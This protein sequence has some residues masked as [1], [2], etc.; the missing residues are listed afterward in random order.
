MVESTEPSERLTLATLILSR[1]RMEGDEAAKRGEQHS[2]C[3]YPEGVEERELER[4]GWLDGWSRAML[5]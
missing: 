5:R 2:L 4:A 1:C 3:P